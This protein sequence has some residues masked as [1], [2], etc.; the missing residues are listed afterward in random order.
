[1]VQFGALALWFGLCDNRQQ[2]M[3]RGFGTMP[4]SSSISSTAQCHYECGGEE[5][6]KSTNEV[7]IS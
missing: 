1:M 3:P 6:K 7:E 5:N 4:L 2:D